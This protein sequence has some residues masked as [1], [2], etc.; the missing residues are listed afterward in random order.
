M[1][2]SG[3]IVSEE[4]VATWCS[5]YLGFNM[6]RNPQTYCSSGYDVRDGSTSQNIHLISGFL[7]V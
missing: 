4:R 3:E 2:V 5:T 1:Y 6:K 7:L